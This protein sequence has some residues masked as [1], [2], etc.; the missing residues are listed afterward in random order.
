MRVW[1]TIEI[2]YS[3]LNKCFLCHFIHFIKLCGPFLWS[4]V[5]FIIH[6]LWM[7]V[8]VC[9]RSK[10]PSYSFLNILL[11]RSPFV[12]DSTAS[13]SL[14]FLTIFF[15]ELFQLEIVSHL[16]RIVISFAITYYTF[17]FVDTLGRSSPTR[18][19]T[20]WSRWKFFLVVENN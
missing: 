2:V 1:C 20:L 16:T 13:C 6:S 3:E 5:E 8:Y 14:F 19:Y 4:V 18:L 10:Q 17:F 11:F 12:N 7:N 9:V 15:L